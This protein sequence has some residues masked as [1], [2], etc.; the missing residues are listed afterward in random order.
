MKAFMVSNLMTFVVNRIWDTEKVED[1][2]YGFSILVLY[3][4]VVC[5]LVTAD[6]LF[7]KF[8]TYL[9]LRVYPKKGD[10]KSD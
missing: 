1:D 2:V 8:V 3:M 6:S 7:H 10:I 9:T 4:V 5:F